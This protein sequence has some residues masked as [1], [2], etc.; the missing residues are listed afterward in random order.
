[1]NISEVVLLEFKTFLTLDQAAHTFTS[2]VASEH[3]QNSKAFCPR[4]ILSGLS[5]TWHFL[6]NLLALMVPQK[7]LFFCINISFIALFAK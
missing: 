4:T 6:L 2:L 1:M 5:Y 3:F 7:R